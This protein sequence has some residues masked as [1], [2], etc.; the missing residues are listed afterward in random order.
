VTRQTIR[1]KTLLLFA[2]TASFG[3]LLGVPRASAQDSGPYDD[4]VTSRLALGSEQVIVTA[5]HYTHTE[6]PT[7]GDMVGVSMSRG[8]RVDDLDLNSAWGRDT[9]RDRV[10][11]TAADVCNQIEHVQTAVASDTPCYA[12]A[13]SGSMQRANFTVRDAY[14]APDYF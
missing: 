3:L 11:S 8:V 12:N 6:G 14:Y 2:A 4:N 13:V 7:G 1:K 9:L 10:R 5:P